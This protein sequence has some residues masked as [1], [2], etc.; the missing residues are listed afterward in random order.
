MKVIISMSVIVGAIA[1]CVCVFFSWKWIATHRG[2][3]RRL[4]AYWTSELYNFYKK[5]KTQFSNNNDT[6]T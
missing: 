5:R 2:N 1:I 4:I 6:S 3:M